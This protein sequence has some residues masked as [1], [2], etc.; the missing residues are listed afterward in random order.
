MCSSRVWRRVAATG[1]GAV[2]PPL[3]E[4]RTATGANRDVL[5]P[6][7]DEILKPAFGAAIQPI[8]AFFALEAAG[9]IVLLAGAVA[10]LAWVNLGGAASYH[11]VL[12]YPVT[13]G[14]GSL[15]VRFTLHEV[16]NE[17]LMTVFFF[18]VGME[19][20]RELAVGEL[21]T[22]ARA[23]LPAVAAVGGMLAPA[24]IFLAFNRGGPG[25]AGW[26]IPMATDIAFTIG[27]LTLLGRRV[28]H[29]LVV[30]VTALAIFDDL[31]GILVIALF[32]GGGL[33]AGWLAAA[34]AVAAAVVLLGRAHVRSGAAYAAGGALLWL[35]LH[36][37]GIHATISGVVLG[38][39]IPARLREPP[40]R[41]LEELARHAAGLLRT[42]SDEEL[43]GEAIVAVERTL[44][45][46]EPPLPRFLHALHPW[47]AFAI[48]PA[49]ALAN[50]GV[51]LR[52]LG[53][54]QLGA[55]V[56]VGTAVALLAGKA[57]GIFSFT[58]AAVKARLAPM[59]RG[60]SYAKL[61]GVS[62]VAGIGF[63]VAL[64]IA[65]LAYPGQPALLDEA[66][67]GILAGSLAAGLLGALVL[68]LTPAAE[69][70]P[71]AEGAAGR[72]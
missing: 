9:G 55:D 35:A 51:D 72:R 46:L 36:H 11:A 28:P 15:L 58:A 19:I 12:A 49:F 67:V 61:L 57:V 40:R 63:T 50:S 45:G 66:K 25:Q 24:A 39:A 2:G 4:T 32:Y 14:A 31:G 60:A 41:S 38:L 22:P 10:A 47:V 53:P 20:K 42:P 37:A 48:M 52:S 70:S 33:H 5:R 64:F 3:H 34:G 71:P 26:G 27:V 6:I 59:P 65:A 8:R 7:H 56:A 23:A 13:V 17:G 62:I 18:V 54:S 69:R 1:S 44:E 30:F 16:V 29:A 21:R 68:R 43:D